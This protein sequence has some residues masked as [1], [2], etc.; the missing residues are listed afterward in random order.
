LA[1]ASRLDLVY[2]TILLKNFFFDLKDIQPLES[3]SLTGK[4]LIFVQ[5]DHF[6]RVIDCSAVWHGTIVRGDYTIIGS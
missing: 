4:K 5:S 6:E 1:C 2:V 3:C